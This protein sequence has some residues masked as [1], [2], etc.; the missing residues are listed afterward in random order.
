MQVLINHVEKLRAK[1]E[2]HRRAWTFG[3]SVGFTALIALVW[4]VN[5]SMNLS[6][7]QLAKQVEPASPFSQVAGV[8]S[9]NMTAVKDGF[10][11]VVS[12]LVS[13]FQ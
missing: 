3:L 1:P 12:N 8:A 13:L 4:G 2:H 5:L 9:A 10:V 11:T 6:T 7:S